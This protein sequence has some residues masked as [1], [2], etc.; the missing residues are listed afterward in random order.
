[1]VSRSTQDVRV[2]EGD[3]LVLGG[4]GYIESGQLGSGY[5]ILS[6]EYSENDC[7]VTS[8]MSRAVRCER[9]MFE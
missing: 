2:N 6:M 1:M 5:Y 9:A 4:C 3:E 8:W 7:P